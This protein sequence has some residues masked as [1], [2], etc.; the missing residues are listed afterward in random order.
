MKNK[1]IYLFQ[2]LMILFFVS[3]SDA[4]DINDS[5]NSPS[6]VDGDLVLPS[7]QM[8][9]AGSVNGYFGVVGGIWSQH[10]TQSHVASQYRDE[11][12]YS[13]TG[14][15]GDYGIPW[16]ELYSDALVDLNRVIE[17]A[18]ADENNNLLLMSVCLK[19]YTYQILVDL[20]DQLPYSEALSAETGVTQPK[21]DDGKTVYEGLISELDAALALDLSSASNTWIQTDFVFGAGGL[22]SQR[23]AWTQFANTLKLKM[24]LR[25]TKVND[26]GA[27][28]AISALL[29]E[30]NF[31]DQDA[32]IDVFSDIT[33]Q[34]YPLYE[35]N[36]RQLNV[37]TNLRASRTFLSWL[38][39]FDDP[40]LDI[41][42]TA[43]SGG[44]FGL[45]QG[46][47][48]IPGS[49]LD[50][51]LVDVANFSPTTPFYFFAKDEVE[52]MLAEAHLRYGDPAQAKAFYEM[53]V[54]DA[55]S[56]VGAD[57]SGILEAAYAYPDGD[58]NANLKAII[59]QKW[60]ASVEMG[61]ESFFDHN[62]TGIPAISPVSSDDGN[63]VPGEFTYSIAGVTGGAFPKRLIFPAYSRRTNQN[64]P[65]EVPL[66]VPVWWAN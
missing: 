60:A 57:C 64:T 22:A 51:G 59:T 27:S 6:S 44:H 10:W 35:T 23:R 18:R 30:D 45:R 53:A 29:A 62:R 25:Q 14:A 26:A 48:D 16:R 21:F 17:G 38:Q 46:D 63:Y 8:H 1:G 7:A 43:G 52:F 12:R 24:W 47:I 33:D 19:A 3:C 55:C 5:P 50:G 58:F 39:E 4:L 42:F 49:Q 41:Y 34:S 66:T 32:K 9:I 61:Y 31:L 54:L 2:L 15:D 65:A 11:D 40:R 20:Y 36:V 56:R 37:A 13:L 28:S